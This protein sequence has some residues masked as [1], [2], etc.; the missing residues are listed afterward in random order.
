M[1]RD[2]KSLATPVQYMSKIYNQNTN[3]SLFHFDNS[4]KLDSCDVIY[5]ST[6]VTNKKIT[7]NIKPNKAFFLLRH[8]GWIKN[9]RVKRKY[10]FFVC[11]RY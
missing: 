9:R 11:S 4:L 5:E 7:L 8:Q 2:Q 3:R 10:N 1:A 6:F